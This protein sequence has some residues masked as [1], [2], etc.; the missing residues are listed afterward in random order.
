[1]KARRLLSVML[2]LVTGFYQMLAQE[3]Y[4]EFTEIDA[5]L[6]FYY[7]THRSSRQG[8][9]YDLNVGS[10]D[11]A[12]YS[13]G[14]SLKVRSV[15][16]N[17]SFDAVRPTTT[18][19]WFYNM[20]GLTT[21]NLRHLNTSEVTNMQSMFQ[22]CQS[23]T[24]LDLSL[25]NTAKVE[26]F[27][28][29]FSQCLELRS[30]DLRGFDTRSAYSMER[31]FYRCEELTEVNLVSF[32]T[33]NVR[34]MRQMFYGCKALK[35]IY[36]GSG[37]VT[38]L[39]ANSDG[40][41][42]GCTSLVGGAGTRYDANHVDASYAHIDGGSSNPGYFSSKPYDF[43]KNGIY[44]MDYGH[45]ALYVTFKDNS[46]GTYSGH[47]LVPESVTTDEWTYVVS[48]IGEKAFY[49]CPYL[50][51]V[52]VPATV[53]I[54][55]ADAFVDAFQDPSHASITCLATTPPNVSPYAFD[56]GIQYM[57]LNVPPG[58]KSAFQSAAVWKGF[59][60]I[61]EI[62]LFVNGIYYNITGDNTVEV[63]Y[64]DKNYN[65]YSGDVVI[66]QS[67]TYKGKNYTVTKIGNVAFLLCSDLTSVTLPSTLTAIGNTTFRKCTSL[68][69]ITIPDGVTTI[70]VNAF[71]GCSSLKE[72]VIG[73]GI[74][75]IGTNAFTGTALNGGNIT[76]LATAP[77][78]IASATFDADC[79]QGANVYVPH[80]CK[81]AYT[82][83]PYWKNFSKIHELGG[84][85]ELKTFNLWIAGRQ[86]TSKNCRNI[87]EDGTVS[88]DMDT[89]TLKLRYASIYTQ[90][91]NA[92]EATF[93]IVIE[94]EGLNIIGGKI[95]GI[96]TATPG[97]ETRIV[98][99][100]S[101][102]LTG[103]QVA[104]YAM[105]LI[106]ESEVHAGTQGYYGITASNFTVRGEDTVV[107]MKGGTSA[108]AI[109]TSLNLEDGLIIGQPVGARYVGNFI[110]D[111]SG[112]PV[113]NDWVVIGSQDYITGLQSL[114]DSPSKDGST[115]NLAGQKVGEDYKGIVVRDGKKVLRR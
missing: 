61:Q 39:V 108:A 115:Y 56:S 92:I 51:S 32:I 78:A 4:A 77:P 38:S 2:L 84:G 65:S 102:S 76:C 93:P 35:S 7:D 6:T 30:L 91:D 12:W 112:N 110:V 28:F 64:K 33:G 82:S 80:G 59:G 72:V 24:T 60:T 114:S 70:G 50:E 86:V 100:G 22:D 29:M 18:S 57:T 26:N 75:S 54:I 109:L 71:D 66:P 95:A 68:T 41:F 53:D 99:T 20:K 81:G 74:Q 1:M 96:F 113:V 11:P 9:T 17:P 45:G 5:S 36:I 87:L 48:G 111:A 107:K 40:M 89:N 8:K 47:V 55:E 97:V 103:G 10:A 83:A 101:L 94:L 25:L 90:A 85:D 58:C 98:G 14:T 31:M 37:W 52:T 104:L 79:Y 19:A 13:D 49:R 27:D 69:S 46:Y 105:D 42:G 43:V 106:I 15:Y 3:A 16:F 62:P 67:I 73:S 21:I 44:Y 88:F 34:K 63:T 23:L